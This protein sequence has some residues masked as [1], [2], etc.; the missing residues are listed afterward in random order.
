MSFSVNKF[1]LSMLA[2][3]IVALVPVTQ[4]GFAK[5]THDMSKGPEELIELLN[6]DD[7]Q[8][9]SFLEIMHE[10][11]EQRMALK[12]RHHSVK[13]KQYDAI[14]ADKEQLRE[15]TVTRLSTILTVAQV[16][17][18]EVFVAQKK[19]EHRCRQGHIHH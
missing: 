17:A 16:E 9:E 12:E 8:Q 4:F 13:V 2:F 3:S 5:N 1:R 10:Q 11:H 19:R 14:R 15:Q 7:S 6:V 18:F